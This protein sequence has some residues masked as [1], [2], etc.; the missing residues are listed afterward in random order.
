MSSFCQLLKEEYG[1]SLNDEANTYIDYAV[2][3]AKRMKILIGDLLSFSRI[4]AEETSVVPTDAAESL[5][6]ALHNLHTMIA[7]SHCI[8]TS[9]DLPLV[10]ANNQLARLFQNLVG[11]GIKYRDDERTPKIHVGAT[12]RDGQW[13]FSVSDNG[14]GIREE[15]FES[16]FDIFKR[17]HAHDEYT[18]T[19]I[20]LAICKEIVDGWHGRLWLESK[21]GVGSTFFFTADAAFE[22]HPPVMSSFT[23][24]RM[25][26]VVQ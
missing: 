10:M 13:V 16:V 12:E 1:S 26:S 15:Y 6:T 7:E 18:G 3:G 23:T 22:V 24:M 11:N 20:G 5:S 25:M 19:G 8:V 4:S 21:E 14:I 2:N 17:L 9:D